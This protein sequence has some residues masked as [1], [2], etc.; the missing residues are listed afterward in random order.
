MSEIQ[1]GVWIDLANAKPKQYEAVLVRFADGGWN[2]AIWMGDCFEPSGRE[3]D[4]FA[5]KISHWLR[6]P[7]RLNL[8]TLPKDGD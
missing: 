2:S 8:P 3:G 5:Y 6:V 4:S 7:Q 1:S